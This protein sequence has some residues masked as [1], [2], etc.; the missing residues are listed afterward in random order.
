MQGTVWSSGRPQL[1]RFIQGTPLR[2]PLACADCETKIINPLAVISNSNI[3]K[4]AG[5]ISIFSNTLRNSPSSNCRSVVSVSIH[6]FL[7][8]VGNS[9]R[10]LARTKVSSIIRQATSTFCRVSKSYGLTVMRLRNFF[11]TLRK[12]LIFVCA[13]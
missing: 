13:N 6:D 8:G 10:V 3:T 5:T 9:L 4:M 12:I 7:Q 1:K 2:Q 11:L